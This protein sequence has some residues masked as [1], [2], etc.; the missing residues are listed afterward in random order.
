MRGSRQRV[1]S[2]KIKKRYDKVSKNHQH[3]IKL[4]GK[5]NKYPKRTHSRGILIS[6]II[7][8]A[9]M[10]KIIINSLMKFKCEENIKEKA[11]ALIFQKRNLWFRN[12]SQS[13]S[14]FKMAYFEEFESHLHEYTQK[15]FNSLITNITKHTRYLTKTNFC[16]HFS[17]MAAEADVIPD[18]HDTRRT[19]GNGFPVPQG[20]LNP[21]PGRP[22]MGKLGIMKRFFVEHHEDHMLGEISF[23]VYRNPNTFKNE[24]LKGS[25]C[26]RTYILKSSSDVLNSSKCLGADVLLQLLKNYCRNKDIKTAIAV[27][28]VGLPNVGKSSLINSLKRSKACGV[29]ATPGFTKTLQEVQLDSKLRLLDCPGIILP[30]GDTSSDAAAALRNA[31]K[32]EQLEDPI[33]PIE[34]IL[35]RADKQQL[36]LHYRLS[37]FSNS[38]EFLA[39][40]CKRMGKLKKGGVPDYE[41]AARAVLHDW[42]IG[43]IKYY[44]SPPV[45]EE[46]GVAL[47]TSLAP[48]FDID[49][50]MDTESSVMAELPQLRPSETI[51]VKSAGPLTDV[52][53]N[54]DE[55]MEDSSD[56]DDDQEN[57]AANEVLSSNVKITMDTKENNKEEE[58]EKKA[59]WETEPQDFDASTMSFKKFQKKA[60]KKA[61]KEGNRNVKRTDELTDAF[62][63]FTG[64]K[65]KDDDYDFNDFIKR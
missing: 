16:G 2:E 21:V 48:E 25:G 20:Q 54:N 39:L 17:K 53:E 61:R 13:S 12:E 29:G 64:L 26:T 18:S 57:N 6:L 41:T 51:M 59:R 10:P 58:A 34:A 62:T 52:R 7:F 36:M 63:N 8:L 56:D 31:V 15:F 37:E 38:M 44:T 24:Q 47:L 46:S 5:N 40:L 14:D 32:L 9:I 45:V 1:N 49:S 23:S 55:D 19:S 42:N 43:N 50:L 60:Q 35:A 27:G 22:V 33:T 28:V 65:D 3:Y 4:F 30:G 11:K